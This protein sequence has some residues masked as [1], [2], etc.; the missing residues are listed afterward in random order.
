MKLYR[1][2]IRNRG[3]NSRGND[4]HPWKGKTKPLTVNMRYEGS[5]SRQVMRRKLRD[6]Y[7]DGPAEYRR[8]MGLPDPRPK[9]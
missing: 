4:W 9:K 5:E 7:V 6:E 1:K 2:T 8:R 3:N